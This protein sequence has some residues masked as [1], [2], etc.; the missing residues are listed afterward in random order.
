MLSKKKVLNL[1]P[2]P[3]E[4]L[5]LEN[6]SSGLLI[7]Y[8]LHIRSSDRKMPAK[9]RAENL[10]E[11]QDVGGEPQIWVWTSCPVP[12]QGGHLAIVT[13]SNHHRPHAGQKPDWG[14]IRNV[15]SVTLRRWFGMSHLEERREGWCCKTMEGC[16]DYTP[17]SSNKKAKCQ[18]VS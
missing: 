6:H 10:N 2:P 9:H 12:Q 8:L 11:M 7:W 1:P 3:L 17:S 18:G 13:G 4:I 16:S 5:A 15:F 14:R